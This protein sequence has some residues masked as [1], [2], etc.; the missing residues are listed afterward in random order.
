MPHCEMKCSWFGREPA[1]IFKRGAL[2][3]LY[4]LYVAKIADCNSHRYP[5]HQH[6]A[7]YK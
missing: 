5:Y 2:N 6:Y 4:N 7:D 3:W 1:L